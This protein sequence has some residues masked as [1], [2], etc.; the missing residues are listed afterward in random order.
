MDLNADLG[1]G[2]GIW[3]LGDDEALLDWS[4][5]PTSPAASTPATR[6]RCAGSA[7]APPNAASR[8]APRSA[9]ATWPASAGGASTYDFDEL[10]DEVHLPDRRAGRRSAGWPAPGS[11]T[12]SRTARSTT[13]RPSTRRRPRRVVAA[14]AGYDRDAA[15]AR[16]SPARCSPSSRPAARPA[17]GRRGL[18]RPRLPARRARWCRAHAPARSSPMRTQVAARAVRMARERQVVAVDG[19]VVPLP[20][21]SICLHGDTPGRGRLATAVRAALRAAEPTPAPASRRRPLGIDPALVRSGRDLRR[22]VGARCPVVTVGV[23]R[24]GRAGPAAAGSRRPST[25]RTGTPQSCRVRWQA[26]CSTSASQV[27][28]CATTCSTPPAT[29]GVDH[30]P[31]GQ[32]GVVPAPR[33]SSSGGD[34]E[35]SS[36]VDGPND[37]SSFWP[38]RRRE[39]HVQRRPRRGRASVGGRSVRCRAP[40]TVDPPR[41]GRPGRAGSAGAR[42]DSTTSTVAVRR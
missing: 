13:P 28:A 24:P 29:A 42:P 3:R 21:D 38:G 23:R 19:T 4:P 8:S 31:A 10:R 25:T 20:V 14:V 34:A 2:F 5:A 39:D 1:E 27:A 40:A 11:A 7:P 26:A 37:S 15:G 41:P 32:L 9:T 18:R 16:A 33:R 35:T 17:G 30:Q 36:R 12:S 22:R 6:P